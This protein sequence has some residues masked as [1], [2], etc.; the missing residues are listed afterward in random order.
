MDYSTVRVVESS[1]VAPSEATPRK[2]LWL[3][4]LDLLMAKRGHTPTFY[5]FNHNVAAS[6]FFDVAR[7]KEA[8]AKALVP[9]YP[10]AGRLGVDSSGRMEI[11]C[12]GEGALFVVANADGI[13][14]DEIKDVKPSPELR[15]QLVP[16]IEPSSVV[17]AVQVT[18]FRCGGVALGTALHHASSDAMSAFHFFQTWSAFSRDG[19]RAAVELPCHDRT[20]LR[21][22]SPPTVHPDALSMFHPNVAL[23]DPSGPITIQVFSISKDQVASLKRLCGGASTFCAVSALLWR[24]ACAA[25]RLPPDA[26]ALLT[27]AANVRRRLAPPLPERYFGNALVRAGVAAA[28]REIIAPEALPTVA[29]RIGDVVRR[30]DDDEMVRSAIDYVEGVEM[31][32]QWTGTRPETELQVT[33]W[34]G[35]PLYDADFGW[36]K[37]RV[38]SRAENNI[39]GSV[40][41]MSDGPADGVRVLM[42]MEVANVEELGRLL[43]KC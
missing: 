10:L 1:F 33:S 36:G 41:L 40:H 24:C 31:S 43:C 12:N 34:L 39:G 20:L 6:D 27:F 28:V 23:C 35:M 21:A 7:L 30:V 37:P 11:D 42:S 15:R 3:S 9:F 32:G 5:L 25:R 18:F 16:R 19:D 2:G 26:E 13:T 8:M 38:M 4:S 29:G 22:R 14:I 17:L